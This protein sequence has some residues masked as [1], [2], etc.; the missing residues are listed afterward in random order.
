MSNYTP[1]S[2]FLQA[3]KNMLFDNIFSVIVYNYR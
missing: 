2:Y 1:V 3:M